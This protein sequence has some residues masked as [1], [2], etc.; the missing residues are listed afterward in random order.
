MSTEPIPPALERYARQI[1]PGALSADQQRKLGQSTALVTRAGGVGGA[2]AMGLVV[3][4]VGRV[5][6]A[7]GGAMIEPDL[8]RQILGADDVVG[9]PR[10]EHFAARLQ[11]MNRQIQVETIDREPDESEC[12]A[13]AQRA[14]ILLACPPTFAER[15]RLNRAAVA[16]HK[17]LVDA[18][19]WGLSGT[20]TVIQPGK[21]ACLAC[22][23]PEE[24]PFEEFFPVLGAIAMVV[25]SIAALEAIKVLAGLGEPLV[26]RM[27]MYDGHTATTTHLKTARRTDCPVCGTRR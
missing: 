2:A 15:L 16:A 19:Q 7:H 9:K 21:S 3:A 22:L 23:Y 5:I 18:A 6:I 4:G 26:G 8:N 11:D 13:L 12:R 25:G 10:A 1:G 24:P 20:V 17:P 27:L 14:D